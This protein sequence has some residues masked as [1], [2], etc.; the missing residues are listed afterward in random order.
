MSV[1]KYTIQNR[2]SSSTPNTIRI[3]SPMDR[4]TSTALLEHWGFTDPSTLFAIQIHLQEEMLT[5]QRTR[6]KNGGM[7]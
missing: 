2:R 3:L 1:Q 7:K 6:K 5:Q 4:V